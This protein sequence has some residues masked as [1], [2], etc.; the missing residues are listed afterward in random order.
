MDD[1]NGK[2]NNIEKLI[3]LCEQSQLVSLFYQD[4]TLSIQFNKLETKAEYSVNT[5]QKD[6][7]DYAIKLKKGNVEIGLDDYVITDTPKMNTMEKEDIITIV[8]PFV[9]TVCFSNQIK[10]GGNDLHIQ[11]GDEVCS[12]E[13]MK[14]YNDIKSPVSGTILKIFV[15]DCSL[16]EYEQ[17]ILEIRADE[18]V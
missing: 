5:Y 18:K 7:K 13:A 11:K 9:G 17:P 1:F 15:N 6:N 12:I 8:S 4:T 3:K 14:I 2:L 16:V 10:L